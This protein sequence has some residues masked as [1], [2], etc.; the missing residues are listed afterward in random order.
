MKPSQRQLKDYG[1]GITPKRGFQ[2]EVIDELNAETN[3]YFDVQ[4]YVVLFD[5]MK[6]LANLVLDKTTGEL[7]GFTDLGD[8]DINP[9]FGKQFAFLKQIATCGW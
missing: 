4:R 1:N 2:K 7:S 5:E 8:P 6:V 3:N 9:S